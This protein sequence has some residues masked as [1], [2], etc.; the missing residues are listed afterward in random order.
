MLVLLI[1]SILGALICAPL[2]V[3]C[4]KLVYAHAR[5][6]GDARAFIVMVCLM[7]LSFIL[8]TLVKIAHLLS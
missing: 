2:F 3:S 4:L 1:L 8:R 7:Y 5:F 6:R